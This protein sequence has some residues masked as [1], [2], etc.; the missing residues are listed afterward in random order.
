[1]TTKKK[2]KLLIAIAL[3]VQLLFLLVVWVFAG[4]LEVVRKW[5]YRNA[6]TQCCRSGCA[7]CPWGNPGAGEEEYEE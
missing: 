1:M 3:P 5:K 6:S 2:N 4:V 7:N